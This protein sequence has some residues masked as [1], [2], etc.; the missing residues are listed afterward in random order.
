ML[1]EPGFWG[2]GGTIA[3]GVFGGGVGH[4]VL[5]YSGTVCYNGDLC[6]GDGGEEVWM[7]VE[8][9]K[10][11]VVLDAAEM[12]WLVGWLEASY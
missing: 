3:T 8:R 9:E 10:D 2:G 5:G 4:F 11:V 6:C 7:T 1:R 12:D